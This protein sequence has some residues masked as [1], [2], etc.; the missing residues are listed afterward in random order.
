[1]SLIFYFQIS[2]I[3]YI[4]FLKKFASITFSKGSITLVEFEV[5]SFRCECFRQQLCQTC[6]LDIAVQ[7]SQVN[8]N[9]RTKLRHE[10]PAGSTWANKFILQVSRNR[11]AI[12]LRVSF[13]YSL[14][15]CGSFRTNCQSITCVL[16]ITA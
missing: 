9:L 8:W 11:Y 7:S 10:L 1:M 14:Y 16:N 6:D 2:F 5:E 13:R 12:E 3:Y 4:R 15:K